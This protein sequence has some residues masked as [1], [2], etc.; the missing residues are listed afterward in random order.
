MPEENSTQDNSRALALIE[1]KRVAVQTEITVVTEAIEVA[2]GVREITIEFSKRREALISSAQIFNRPPTTDEEQEQIL[3]AQRALGKLRNEVKKK[4]DGYKAP[5]NA[6][7][8]KIIEIHDE[9]IASIEKEEKRLQGLVQ[10]RQQKLLEEQRQREAD[11]AAETKRIADEAA[12]AE[13]ARLEA[14]RTRLQAEIAQQQAELAK[15]KKKL[16]AQQEA[17]EAKRKAEEAEEASFL[18][19]LNAEAPRPV[20]AAPVS[21]LTMSKQVVDFTIDG[22]NDVQRK[23][24]MI[25]LLCAHPELFSVHVKNET[26][27]EYSLKLKIAD[28]ADRLNGRLAPAIEAAPGITIRKTLSKLR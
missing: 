2:L 16:Q 19:S 21:D 8:T 1:E 22:D 12:A 27:R 28:T 13:R 20:V 23:A 7:R 3:S 9:G 10:H 25:K 15:G 6:A 18:A 5:F 4:A 24:S 17:E 26:P 11:A 14:E